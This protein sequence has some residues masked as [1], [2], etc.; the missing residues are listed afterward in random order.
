MGKKWKPIAAVLL[1][2]TTLTMQVSAQNTDKTIICDDISEKKSDGFEES[3]WVE[4]TYLDAD[5]IKEDVKGT[6]SSDKL[7]EDDHLVC[8]NTT[9]SMYYN[10][11]T[12]ILK[13]V[14]N[15][16]DYV[17]SSGQQNEKTEELSKRWKNF[18][19]CLV[20]GEF[21]DVSTMTV[22]SY[23][24][25]F[26]SQKTTYL[27]NGIEVQLSF[28]NI[29]CS[30]LVRITLENDKLIVQVP[31]DHIVI[32]SENIVLSRLYVLPFFGATMAGDDDGYMFVPDGSGALIRFGESMTGISSSYVG[33]IY[34]D[35]EAVIGIGT[36]NVSESDLPTT[37]S[38]TAT[39]PVFGMAHGSNQNAVFYEVKEGMEYCEIVANPAGN[40]IDWYWNAPCFIYNELYKQQDNT[41]SGFVMAQSESN[42]VNA[43]F[44]IAFLEGENADYVGMAKYYRDFLIESGTLTRIEN[45]EE[46]IPLLL[47]CLMGE[48]EDNGLFTNGVVLTELSDLSHWDEILTEYGVDNIL[49]SLRGASK[50]GY[51]RQDLDDFSLWNKIGSLSELEGLLENG[52]NLSWQKDMLTAFN[53]QVR[54]NA[55]SY[56]I[57]RVFLEK[58]NNGYLD[59]TKYYIGLKEISNIVSDAIDDMILPSLTIASLPNSLMSNFKSSEKYS[60]VEA[61]ERISDL[62]SSLANHTEYLLLETPNA[63]VF[64]YMDAAYDVPISDSYYLFETDTVPFLQIVLS[65]SVDMFAESNI[66]IRGGDKSVLQLIDYNIYPQF[67]VMA[68]ESSDL[69]KT[70]SNTVSLPNFD[71][72][73][74]DIAE[75]YAA[76][77]EVLSQVQ[78]AMMTD[79]Q[80][81]QEDVVISFYDNG[82]SVIVNYSNEN[83]IQGQVTVGP[84]SAVSI[85][86]ELLQME[87]IEK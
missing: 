39:M 70:N 66:V 76:V 68:S 83:Y 52:L 56:T 75:I 72:V 24:P 3:N 46:N 1:L 74:P 35:D 31:D 50:G 26:E 61:R 16:N 12:S 73:S 85:K 67:T 78:G 9:L 38:M 23:N 51:S 6:H 4:H 84:Q 33:R 55:F 36:G 28:E 13:V 32:E 27:P 80:V 8:S 82:W 10:E 19:H 81:I 43:T 42:V 21:I 79:R 7:N 47:D 60:R 14:D 48:S 64:P 17:W 22:S 41:D 15:R 45:G 86:T 30:L 18:S 49:Y 57:N 25:N 29:D 77:N 59:D 34:G 63:Y 65:G 69:A 53:K 58:A 20:S 40:I 87:G 71:N 62:L 2:C 54:R 11:N 37:N 5:S 44:T